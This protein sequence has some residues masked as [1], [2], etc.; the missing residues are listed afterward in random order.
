MDC[1]SEHI[2][3]NT[4]AEL[5]VNGYLLYIVIRIYRIYMSMETPR[6]DMNKNIKWQST[7]V[8]MCTL[9]QSLA[10][11]ILYDGRITNFSFQEQLFQSQTQCLY[12]GISYP[13]HLYNVFELMIKI[14]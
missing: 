14:L 13:L 7:L 1:V 5:F 9:Y 3:L 10:M 4:L 6:R 12:I 11:M 2:S 8:N